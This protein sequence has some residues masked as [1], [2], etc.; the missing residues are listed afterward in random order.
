MTTFKLALNSQLEAQLKSIAQLT[1]K[2][3]QQLIVEALEKHLQELSQPQN[4]YDLALQLGVIGIAEDLPPDLSTN[5][6]YFEG[7]GQ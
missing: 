3:E 6:D 2:S 5:H 4:C 7:F 1:N